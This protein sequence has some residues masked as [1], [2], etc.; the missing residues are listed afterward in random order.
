M[1]KNIEEVITK[2]EMQEAF[3]PLKDFFKKMDSQRDPREM[4][5][6]KIVDYLFNYEKLLMIA[7]LHS[8]LAMNIIRNKIVIYFFH[9][10]YSEV[11][12]KIRLVKTDEP[13]YYKRVVSYRVFAD[14]LKKKFLKKYPQILNDIMAITVSDK[15]LGRSEALD[16]LKGADNDL[17]QKGLYDRFMRS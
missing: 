5:Y 15:G 12:V 2:E 1:K 16:I 7:R 8:D 3:T 6:A 13:P 9:D 10:Y 17:N 14:N 4:A 11:D